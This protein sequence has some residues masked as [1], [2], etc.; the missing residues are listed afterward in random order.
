MCQMLSLDELT[1]A[2]IE[3]LSQQL[4]FKF[5]DSVLNRVLCNLDQEMDFP[6]LLRMANLMCHLN[7]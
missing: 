7:R 2:W 1:L 6:C 4:P 3:L 5:L